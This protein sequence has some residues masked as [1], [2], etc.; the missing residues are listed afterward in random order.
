MKK[1]KILFF[2]ESM[3]GGVFTYIVDLANELVKKYDMYIAYGIRKQT[4][5]NYRDYFD[6]KIHLI[7]VNSFTRS[8]NPPK[9]LNAFFEL[10][11]IK[12]QVKPDIIHLHSSKA[13][14]IGRIAFINS[15]I[16][17]FYTP[18]GYSFLMQ[19]Q[20]RIKKGLYRIIE[21]LCGKIK[22]T[23]ICC[24]QGE[25]IEACKVTKH[26]VRIDNG[27]NT[28]R[29]QEV[30]NQANILRTDMEGTFTVFILGRICR[31]K[32]P[33]AFN[34]IAQ[35]LP[36]IQFIWIGNGELRNELRSPNITVTGWVDRNQAISLALRSDVFILPSLWEG[37]PISLLEAMYM[38]KPCVVSNVIGNRDVIK[39]GI[40]GYL[41]N[42]VPDFVKA[43]E[44][45]QES[46]PNNYIQKAYS[47]ISSHYNIVKMAEQYEKTYF[48]MH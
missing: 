6:R 32:N 13:G 4:P 41:C 24:S 36:D 12:N 1:K 22:C 16:P 23:T 33:K 28:N 40:N 3:G 29:L 20:K 34:A 44:S 17:L 18:H 38:K 37:L 48:C 26:A 43:I 39:S 30:I 31:Q 45:I 35:S 10:L 19:D 27:I 2:V 15:H 14:V 21:K 11:K 46:Y 42:D 5:D 47:E 25:Y 8:I 9:D 7:R